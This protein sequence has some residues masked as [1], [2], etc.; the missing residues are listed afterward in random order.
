MPGGAVLE[1]ISVAG[2]H[3]DTAERVLRIAK[4]HG[5]AG[6]LPVG[7]QSYRL[8]RSYR[9]TWATV[10]GCVSAPT[11]VGLGFLLV[12]VTEHCTVSIGRRRGQTLVRLTGHLPAGAVAAMREELADG[13][14]EVPG[15]ASTLRTVL[16]RVVEFDSGERAAL[17]A[18]VVVGR[19]PAPDHGEPAARLV[20]V[21]DPTRS[22]SKTHL[23]IG[24]DERGV[25][26][27]DRH[28]TNGTTVVR[29]GGRARECPPGRRVYLEPGSRVVFGER[30]F[31]VREAHGVEAH[32]R[33]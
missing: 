32:P 6:A 3:R 4:R 29:P 14:I 23:A 16:R 26:V 33:F 13:R 19:K 10:A 2:V 15:P 5:V 20:T 7:M 22:V 1:T 8:T 24:E 25:W 21:N 28:S 27:S 30:S 17:G 11:V 9:P 12:R 31:T 18:L